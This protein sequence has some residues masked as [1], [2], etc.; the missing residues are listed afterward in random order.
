MQYEWDAI[1]E[2]ENRRKH[3]VG[4]ELACLV[5]NDPYI[6]SH[7]DRRL[8]YGEERWNSIG[9]PI[10]GSTVLLHVTHTVREDEHGQE[11]I[12]IISA[13]KATPE[14]GRKYA[15]YDA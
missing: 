1:K 14:E 15:R 3:K 8:N 4:F 11:I 9:I 5:F 10:P 13:R 12:R 2:I 6:L 7:L